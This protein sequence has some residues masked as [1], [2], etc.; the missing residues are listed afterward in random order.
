VGGACR[1]LGQA[2]TRQTDTQYRKSYYFF[3]H[4][5]VCLCSFSFVLIQKKNEPKRKNQGS[6]FSATGAP[7]V[8]RSARTRYAQTIALLDGDRLHSCLTQK[9]VGCRLVGEDNECER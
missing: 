1:L 5:I 6:L 3:V 7:S 2:A 9:K 8:A 4:Y